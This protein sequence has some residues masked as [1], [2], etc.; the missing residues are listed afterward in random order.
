MNKKDVKD[1]NNIIKGI[2]LDFNSN[3]SVIALESIDVAKKFVLLDGLI[4]LGHTLRFSPYSEIKS[5]SNKISNTNINK[6]AALANSA[7]LSAKT[8]AIAFAALKNLGSNLGGKTDSLQLNLEEDIQ[9]TMPS[10]RVIKVMNLVDPKEISKLKSEKFEEIEE[11]IKEEFT[12][13]GTIVS[14]VVI[15]PKNEKIGA[16]PASVFIEFLEIKFAEN[17]MK[18]MKGK[19]YEGREIKLGFIDENVYKNEILS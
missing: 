19:C 3:S 13:F 17:C 6:A 11:D 5:D 7:H 14:S 4:L 10:S 9:N 8:A 1:I 16:E 2:E 18:G 12:K 15:N